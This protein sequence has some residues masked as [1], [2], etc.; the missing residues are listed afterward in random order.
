MTPEEKARQQIDAMLTASGWVIQDYKALNLGAAR[1]NH[2]TPSSI[3][4]TP[5]RISDSLSRKL[6]REG[7]CARARALPLFC[8]E[9]LPKLLDEFNEVL[10]A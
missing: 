5:S 9:L 3:S 1:R 10:A 7:R 8:G 6:D 4:T 2:S